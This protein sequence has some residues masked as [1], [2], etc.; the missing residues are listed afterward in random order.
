MG[1]IDLIYSKY[2]DPLKIFSQYK[3]YLHAI[4]FTSGKS[5]TNTCNWLNTLVVTISVLQFLQAESQKQVLVIGLT[6]L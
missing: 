6:H 1:L 2:L 5:G 3:Y 4:I